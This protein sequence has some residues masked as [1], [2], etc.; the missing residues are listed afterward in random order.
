MKRILLAICIAMIPLGAIGGIGYPIY[1]AFWSGHDAGIETP[2][3]NNMANIELTPEMNTSRLLASVTY[4]YTGEPFSEH[5]GF[6]CKIM[7]G[8]KTEY[9]GQNGFTLEND[10]DQGFLKIGD[11]GTVYLALQ[12]IDVGNNK[13]LQVQLK[14]EPH[15]D[16]AIESMTLLVRKNVGSAKP[17]IYVGSCIALLIGILGAVYLGVTMIFNYEDPV[18]ELAREAVPE[19][20]EDENS[21]LS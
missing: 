14:P 5:V 6:D 20:Y 12:D 11:T 10:S 13:T 15:D 7:S 4:R 16:V 8:D 19:L 3:I 17:A 9:E 1:Q 21:N 18:F 2:F